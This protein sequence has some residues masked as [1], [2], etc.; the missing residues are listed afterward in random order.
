MK[1]LY[2]AITFALFLLAGASVQ[3]QCTAN[4]SY[5]TSANTANFTD[6]SST[7][8]GNIISWT[9]DFGDGNFD[10]TQNPSHTYATGGQYLVTL[11]I[12]TNAFCFNS[13]TDTVTVNGGC[14]ASYTY[15]ADTTS[16][17]VAFQAQPMSQNLSYNWI[18][19]DSTTGT[20]PNPSHTYSSSGTYY[21]CLMI[22]D[23]AGFCSD[24]LCDSVVV[25]IAPPPP[26]SATF[27]YNDQGDGSVI[28]TADNFDFNATYDWDFGDFMQGQGGF[29]FHQY[30]LPGTYYVCLTM[31]DSSCTAS[32][33][34][35]VIV[36]ADTS[37]CDA[38]FNHFEN[39][40]TMNAFGSPFSTGSS[41][42]YD[43]DFGDGNQGTGISQTHTYTA[44]GTY[45]VCITYTNMFNQCYDTFCDSVTV[46]DTGVE[47]IFAN[48][49]SLNT[50][51][52]P[53]SNSTYIEFMLAEKVNA[54]VVVFDL[55]GNRIDVIHN[56]DL[57]AGAHTIEWNAEAFS[58]GTYLL[59]IT[60]SEGIAA[61]IVVKN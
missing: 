52:N 4:Y 55:L 29:T 18:F 24:T 10:N 19:G 27:T 50:Y 23:T 6:L 43:W 13:F 47:D 21:V 48:T 39:G 1:H 60:T 16:G 32:F 58:K 33:C 44:A 25:Y 46:I 12:F 45:Y 37:N 7:S 8:A 9:W 30:M 54:E 57:A 49:I 40:L 28:F 41:A 11:N 22:A 53:F 56:G 3:A 38:G 51:P 42:M 59:K 15:T 14:T 61:K 34:D 36:V 5:T 31:S 20:G 17:T 26:C 35:S 2:K